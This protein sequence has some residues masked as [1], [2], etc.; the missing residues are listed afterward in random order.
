[1]YTT[2]SWAPELLHILPCILRGLQ[3][4]TN[5]IQDM[6]KIFFSNMDVKEQVYIFVKLMKLANLVWSWYCDGRMLAY[7]LPP[8]DCMHHFK[9]TNL[10]GHKSE[11]IQSLNINTNMKF[12]NKEIWNRRKQ[13]RNNGVLFQSWWLLSKTWTNYAFEWKLNLGRKNTFL[14]IC[15]HLT[16]WS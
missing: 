8:L 1:M 15:S 7:F 5:K 12:E 9:F 10:H 16:C 2:K 3:N 6:A 14:F 13:N 4:S 11:Q